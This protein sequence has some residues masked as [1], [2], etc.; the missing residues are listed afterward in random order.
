MLSYTGKAIA[1]VRDY[2]FRLLVEPCPEKQARDRLWDT[3]L[4]DKLHDAYCRAMEQGRFLLTIER[5]GRPMTFFNANLQKK[6]SERMAEPLKEMA[7]SF[8]SHSERYVSVRM[9]NLYVADKDNGQQACEDI[10]DILVSYYKYLVSGLST[11]SVS[12]WSLT[13]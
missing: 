2:N 12:K 4:T 5:G 9:I 10:L 6:P 3:L 1:L 11:S 8:R 13:S 7:I